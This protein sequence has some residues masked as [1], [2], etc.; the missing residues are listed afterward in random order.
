MNTTQ[1]LLGGL[2]ALLVGFSKTGVPGLGILIVPLM[3][4][5]FEARLS[6]GALLPMLIVGDVFG[7]AFYRRH[8][9]WSKVWPLLPWVLVGTIP[10]VWALR[11]LDSAAMAPALGWLVLAMIA[12]ELVRRRLDWHQL[13]HHAAFGAGI[14]VAIGFATTLGNIAGPIMTIYFLSRGVDK[15]EFVGTAAWLFLI[16]NVSKLPIFAALGMITPGTLAFN[17]GVLPLIVVGAFLGKWTLPRI[18]QRIFSA[19]VMVLAAVAA[20]RLIW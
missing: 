14:G 16:I 17:L 9:D 20:A 4:T 18:P 15:H 13:P 10:G 3:A 5:V 12:V 2:A 7:V 19:L 8:A 6:V 1:L 11:H